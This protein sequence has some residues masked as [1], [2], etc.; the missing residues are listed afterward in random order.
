MLTGFAGKNPRGLMASMEFR[1]L[2]AALGAL[3]LLAPVAGCGSDESGQTT[4]P[5]VSLSAPTSPLGTTQAAPAATGKQKGS[6]APP[7]PAA[8][9]G[10]DIPAS[11]EDF[12]F[13]GLACTEALAVANAWD[14]NQNECNTID[15]PNSPEG[16]K[17]SCT[18]ED[19]TCT[20]KRD[21]HSDGRFVAC[22]K[23]SASVRF[24]WYPA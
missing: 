16:Y 11:F 21:V 7:A 12:K 10:C 6:V 9:G 5:E 1:R 2:I 3:A 19:F 4:T 24:T 13:S 17:R 20:A 18:V 23:G 15:N 8:S 14:E 22:T